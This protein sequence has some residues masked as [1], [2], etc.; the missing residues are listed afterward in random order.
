VVATLA[1]AAPV[2][3]AAEGEYVALGDSYAAGPLI[4][5]QIEPFGCLKSSSNYG[6]LAQLKLLYSQYT[7][8]TCS[9]AETEDMTAPQGVTPGP[10]PPQFDALDAGTRLVT[11]TIGGN[12]IGFSGIAQDCINLTPANAGHPCMDKYVV[13]GVDAVSQRIAETG[14]KV[15]AVIQGIR[16][17]SPQARILVLN[18]PAIFPHTGNRGCWPLIP[19]ADG[20]VPWLRS[21]QVELNQ[22]VAAQAVANGAVLVDAYAASRGRD[23]CSLP[24]LRWLEPAVPL[25]LAA[26]VHPNLTGMLGMAKLVIAAARS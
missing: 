1:L 19:V 8:M 23:A 14:P 10:N 24:F 21:K 6:H 13:N 7:D 2:A 25:N 9:G 15:A 12:D 18:Y 3:S 17:R 11:I 5:V 26:P 4:P 22:M 16:A 20:D